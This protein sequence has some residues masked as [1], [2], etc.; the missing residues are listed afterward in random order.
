M[1]AGSLCLPLARLP[2]Y[3]HMHTTAKP[4]LYWLVFLMRIWITSEV[5]AGVGES[6]VVLD[7]RKG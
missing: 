1:N 6:G 2:A 3:N 4:M 5:C 7:W